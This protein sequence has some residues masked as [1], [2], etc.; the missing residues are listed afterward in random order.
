M[1]TLQIILTE[2]GEYSDVNYYFMQTSL[3]Y[4]NTYLTNKSDNLFLRADSLITLSNIITG[5]RHIGLRD[6]NVKPVGYSKNIW[7]SLLLKLDYIL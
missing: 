6:V 5:S 3:K 7:T 4:R 1:D 2:E